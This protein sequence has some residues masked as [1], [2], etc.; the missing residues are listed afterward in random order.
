M[1][2]RGEVLG[3]E[4]FAADPEVN[5]VF[6]RIEGDIA[7]GT[8]FR[9]DCAADFFVDGRGLEGAGGAV[10]EESGEIDAD[11]L[12]GSARAAARSGDGGGVVGERSGW[13][14]ARERE[15]AQE[16]KMHRMV[17]EAE[18]AAVTV[19]GDLDHLTGR[20]VDGHRLARNAVG[21]ED[22]PLPVRGP[23]VMSLINLGIA[24]GFRSKKRE[25]HAG[26]GVDDDLFLR[27]EASADLSRA[28]S[29]A[30]R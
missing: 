3:G 6:R 29:G 20:F 1:G 12:S 11:D 5:V 14:F 23:L 7:D 24:G 18:H 10:G 15:D 27:R 28:R 16:I 13:G 21:T 22:Q 4:F 26:H 30:E 2:A 9:R 17:R 8:E 25:R 19:L